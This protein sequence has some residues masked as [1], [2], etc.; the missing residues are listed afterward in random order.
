VAGGIIDR[1]DERRPDILASGPQGGQGLVDAISGSKI[2][3]QDLGQPRL[4]L[5]SRPDLVAHWCT[6]LV[7]VADA[8]E[9]PPG[10]RPARSTL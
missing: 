4:D 5:G 9:V 7:S 6:T 10:H 8:P 3:V 1:D 2:T